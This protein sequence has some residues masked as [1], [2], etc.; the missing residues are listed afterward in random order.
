MAYGAAEVDESVG[1]DQV[2]RQEVK[3]VRVQS[4]LGRGAGVPCDEAMPWKQVGL[5]LDSARNRNNKSCVRVV[6]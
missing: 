5:L 1:I 4:S 2:A 3:R 6:P